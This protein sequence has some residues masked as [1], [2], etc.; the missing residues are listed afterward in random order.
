[1]ATART[2]KL[3]GNFGMAQLAARPIQTLATAIT[4]DRARAGRGRVVIRL[5][6]PGGG[7][8]Q[9]ENEQRAD[10]PAGFAAVPATRTRNP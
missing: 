6:A 8:Q 7:G 1:V 2:A 4:A 3:G 9:P 10:D 5:A